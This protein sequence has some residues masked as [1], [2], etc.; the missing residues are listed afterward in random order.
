MLGIDPRPL[1]FREIQYAAKGRMEYDWQH[2]SMHMWIHAE[3]NRNP[4]KRAKPFTPN[5]FNAFQTKQRQVKPP[6]APITALKA[7][8]RK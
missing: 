3:L 4:K 1:T 6:P 8:I 5:D 2:T 7:L